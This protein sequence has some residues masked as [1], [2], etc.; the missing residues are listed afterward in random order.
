[1]DRLDRLIDR[2]APLSLDADVAAASRAFEN[3][4]D[5]QVLAVVDSDGRPVGLL[6]RQ[7]F[8]A[9]TL[10]GGA[11]VASVMDL[12]PLVVDG[13]LRTSQF[14]DEMLAENR[15]A[16]STGF[17]VTEAGLYLGVGTA[18]NLLAARGDR[19]RALHDATIAT[20]QVLAAEILRQL[21]DAQTFVDA[22]IRQPLPA[23]SKS[24]AQALADSFGDLHR[25]MHRARAIQATEAGLSPLEPRPTLLRE[26]IDSLEA[27]WAA[28]AATAGVTLLTAYDG[29][30]ELAADL[31]ADRLAELLDGLVE[32]ALSA[33]RRGAVEVTL[34][35]RPALEG[36]ALEARVRDAGQTP[37]PARLARIFEAIDGEKPLAIGF[38]MAHAASL[39]GAMNGVIRA[40]TNPG[41]GATVVFSLL[42]PEAVEQVAAP[43]AGMI[44]ASAAH[45]LIVD[46]NATNRM[47]A[48][49]LCEMFDCTSEQAVDGVEAVEMAS[50]GRYDLI[51]MDIKM[52]RMDGV[53]ATHAIRAL[54]GR[55]GKVPIIALTAN[56]DPEDAVGYLA[57]GM[58]GV[59]EKP[60]KPENLLKALQDNLGCEEETAAAA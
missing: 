9:A 22:L 53:T 43:A 59:V 26:V 31:D 54:P 14:R 27:R 30:P 42:A 34:S 46:D 32:R 52:P 25:L 17:I 1:M 13:G 40:E 2:R 51:L 11:P 28:R 39:A 23:D 6:R 7:A 3:Q 57:A 36:L 37:D 50:I 35:A 56:A 29:A 21:D 38:G 18:V 48:E 41:S 8:Q 60:M 20:T 33:T 19:S 58:N 4:P 55:A 24:C 5:A 44:A 12:A 15:L 47:V 16:L 49:A 45:I 10:P